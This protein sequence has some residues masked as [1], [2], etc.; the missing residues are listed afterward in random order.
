VPHPG[1]FEPQQLDGGVDG[2]GRA[3]A[4]RI[5]EDGDRVEDGVGPGVAALGGGHGGPRGDVNK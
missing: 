5:P 3:V 4:D 1:A 2:A